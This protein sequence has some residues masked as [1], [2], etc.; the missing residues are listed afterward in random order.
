MKNIKPIKMK[1][2][3]LKNS[4]K[5]FM[6][7]LIFGLTI[8]SCKKDDV[9][10]SYQQTVIPTDINALYESKG[11]AVKD[12]VI[13]YAHG[14]PTETLQLEDVEELQF[15]N[16]YRVYVKQA[17]HINSTIQENEI[18]FAQATA[19]DAIST[20]MYQNV[21]EHFVNQG[22]VV[23]AMSHSFGSFIIPNV[24]A[25]KPN[26]A[27]KYIIMAGRLDMPEV[28]WQ[29]FRD[30]RQ[31]S[32]ENGITP[33]EDGGGTPDSGG[34]LSFTRLQAGLGQNR[35]TQ[36]LVDKDLTNLSYLYGEL[37]EPVGRLSNAEVEFLNDKNASAITITNGGHSS[38]FEP[39]ILDF[40]LN[41]IIREN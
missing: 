30:G 10:S 13:V 12:T 34:E 25:T 31:Y 33:V 36:L 11:L 5:V 28:V 38:M 6:V 40:I 41:D 22:K 39:I 16:Y 7:I 29:G 23:V 9:S 21:L 27:Y 20:D 3:F 24:L 35:F 2:D 32:F 17:Q 18:T 26:I 8:S 15:E 1:N 4:I 37:D 14:G 19:E